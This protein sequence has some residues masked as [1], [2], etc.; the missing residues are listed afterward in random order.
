[1]PDIPKT[2]KMTYTPDDV[3]ELVLADARA[4]GV[5]VADARALVKAKAEGDQRETWYVGV[6]EGFEVDIKL[7]LPKRVAR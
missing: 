5:E 3:K 7:N 2:A 6:F 1:M 4:R